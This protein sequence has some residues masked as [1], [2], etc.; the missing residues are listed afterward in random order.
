MTASRFSHVTGDDPISFFF[1][2]EFHCLHVPH[3]PYPF[4]SQWTFRVLIIFEHTYPLELASLVAQRVKHL[5]ARRE[6]W[7]RSLGQEDLLEKEM[8]THSGTL[9]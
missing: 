9:A 1:M 8:A 7:V 5:P 3:L 4:N 2:T 6:A